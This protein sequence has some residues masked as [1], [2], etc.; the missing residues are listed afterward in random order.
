MTTKYLNLNQ[1]LFW[2]IIK[3]Y[4]LNCISLFESY[5]KILLFILVKV[6]KLFLLLLKVLF[7]S[8]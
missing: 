2:F 4:D 6:V 3:K 8:V 5:Y 1:V 7:Y